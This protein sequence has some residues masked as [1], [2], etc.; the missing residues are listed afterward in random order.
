M[1][2]L[3]GFKLMDENKKTQISGGF[4][5]A[6]LITTILSFIPVVFSALGSTIGL[7]KASQA[8]SGEI[9]LKDFNAKWES[10]NSNIGYSVGFH[11]C[12]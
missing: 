10:G 8:E 3:K 12:I 1:K 6:S 9:K 11:Y 5:A 2:E 4:A 7:I